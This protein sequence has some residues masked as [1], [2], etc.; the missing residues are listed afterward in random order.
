M[1]LAE[2]Q[3]LAARRLRGFAVLTGV[4]AVAATDVLAL[5]DHGLVDGQE[6]L[7]VS[8]TGFGGLTAGTTYFAR[9]VVDGVSFKLAATEDGAAV[10]L[11]SNGS[12]GVLHAPLIEDLARNPDQ[13]KRDIAA[14]LRAAGLCVEIGL[15][16]VLTAENTGSGGT[17]SR[18]ALVIFVAE[19][20][21][22]AHT[23][24]GLKLVDAVIE[25]LRDRRNQV[26]DLQL[27]ETDMFG[28][29]QGYALALLTVGTTARHGL[30]G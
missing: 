23:P 22:V 3:T 30:P 15:P 9:D 21:T 20:P 19:S 1:T 6:V 8:G 29:E 25:A 17:F 14:R 12:A 27:I 28:T 4:S 24:A 2:I 18:V 10:D 7:Y 16:T 5:A 11:T 13:G 26:A